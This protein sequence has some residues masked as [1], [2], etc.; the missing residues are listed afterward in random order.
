MSDKKLA[1][2]LIEAQLNAVNNRN[3]DPSLIRCEVWNPY[4]HILIFSLQSQHIEY[5]RNNNRQTNMLT[6]SLKPGAAV[7]LSHQYWN[8]EVFPSGIKQPFL[9]MNLGRDIGKNIRWTPGPKDENYLNWQK[10]LNTV[11]NS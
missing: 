6:F 10:I 9:P 3:M 8:V 5:L 11:N 4:K 2:D 7:V 1:D